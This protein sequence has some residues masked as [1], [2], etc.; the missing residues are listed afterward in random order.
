MFGARA[1]LNKQVLEAEC[2]VCVGVIEPH[3][4]AGY[5]GGCKTVGIG[6]ASRETI[7]TMHGL[8][9]L[10][11]SGARPGQLEGN[12]FRRALSEVCA[13]LLPR[14]WGFQMAS[15]WMGWGPVEA[16]FGQGAAHV[17]ATAFVSHPAPYPW[18]HVRVPASKAVSFYQASRGATY[19][20]LVPRSVVAA[21]G[22]ILVEAGCEEGIGLGVGERACARAMGRGVEALRRDLRAGSR[23]EPMEGGE[24]R[25]YVVAMALESCRIALVGAG[26]GLGELEAM[27][28]SQWD[29]LESALEGLGLEAGEGLGNQD[30]F[31]AIPVLGNPEG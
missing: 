12:L 15:D 7:A 26:A 3:Q 6:C 10:A 1:H 20:A 5:S 8:R 28:I 14:M 13:P 4:Y 23:E 19:V 25:A 18:V 16:V 22:V 9:L 24:Q 2:V 17:A 21:G 31:E 27:G 29:S 30:P 11:Q